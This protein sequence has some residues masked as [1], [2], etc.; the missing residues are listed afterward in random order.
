MKKILLLVACF[1]ITLGH[2]QMQEISKQDKEFAEKAQMNNLMEQKLSEMAMRKGFAPEVKELAQHMLAN[3]RGHNLLREL[4]TNKSIPVYN[5]LDDE[6]QKAYNEMDV[7]SG[8]EFDKAYTECMVKDHKDALD[9]YEKQAKK[10]ENTELRAFAINSQPSLVSHRNLAEETC[11]KL[12]DKKK[13]KGM[14]QTN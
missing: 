3:E 6:H 5:K 11:K 2:A 12:K 13:D 7:K 8:E 4:S 1:G 14:A 10:G 9:L